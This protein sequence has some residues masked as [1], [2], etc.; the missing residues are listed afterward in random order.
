MVI[1]CNNQINACSNP[2]CNKTSIEPNYKETN[3]TARYISDTIA[4]PE[5][6]IPFPALIPSLGVGQPML[7][8]V[9]HIL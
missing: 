6:L 4:G 2:K 5:V 1:T 8:L 9:V 7:D 3:M